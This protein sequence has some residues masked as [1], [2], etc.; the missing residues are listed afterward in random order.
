[1]LLCLKYSKQIFFSFSFLMR[2][3]IK[4]VILITH[5]ILLRME[6]YALIWM[7]NYNFFTLIHLQFKIIYDFKN[8]FS[9]LTSF[10]FLRE[11]IFLFTILVVDY[12]VRIWQFFNNFHSL[13]EFF[14]F[15]FTFHSINPW[16]SVSYNFFVIC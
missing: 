1:M 12:L 9:I 15:F 11:E 16:I 3:K 14:A 5:R 13:H 7:R 2:R 4:C 8:S 10:F 6:F